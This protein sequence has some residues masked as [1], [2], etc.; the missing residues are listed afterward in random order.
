MKSR[1][2]SALLFIRLSRVAEYRADIYNPE[3]LEQ[4]QDRS[5]VTAITA[6]LSKCLPEKGMGAND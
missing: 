4:R 5:S 2:R 6:V 1:H 3:S